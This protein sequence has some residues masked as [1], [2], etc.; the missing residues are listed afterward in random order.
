MDAAATEK[1]DLTPIEPASSA[2]VGEP[3]TPTTKIQTGHRRDM[4]H[5]CM[6]LTFMVS[7][8]RP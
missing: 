6:L 3:I 8:Y 1:E 2:A 7:D 5:L 4:G